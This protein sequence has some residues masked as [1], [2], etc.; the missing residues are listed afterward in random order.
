[1][2][3]MSYTQEYRS[4]PCVDVISSTSQISHDRCPRQIRV[5]RAKPHLHAAPTREVSRYL[6]T[7]DLHRSRHSGRTG[8]S[9]S[10]AETDRREH[11]VRRCTGC[12][13]VR[14]GCGETD[15]IRK[16]LSC[17]SLG[18]GHCI[19]IR[20]K[21]RLMPVAGFVFKYVLSK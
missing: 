14:F 8:Q 16:M 2:N 5:R 17:L 15:E 7:P 3:Y 10:V 20:M 19:E 18:D 11:A 4:M 9:E 1:M 12:F 21:S 6:A 13:F